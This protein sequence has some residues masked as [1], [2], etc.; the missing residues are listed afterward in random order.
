MS[1]LQRN[2][3]AVLVLAA[4]GSERLGLGPKAGLALGGRP[5]LDWVV[6]KALQIGDRVIMACAPG[7]RAPPKRRW[8]ARQDL[9]PAQR[10]TSVKEATGWAGPWA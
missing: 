6:D 1:A 10:Q 8:W 3:V 5:L 2:Q 4:G 7:T 9:P